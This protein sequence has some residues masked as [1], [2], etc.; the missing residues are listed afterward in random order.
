MSL[1]VASFGFAVGSELRT[2]TI[3]SGLLAAAAIATF[4][5]E[6]GLLT[7]SA[8]GASAA[9]TPATRGSMLQTKRLLMLMLAIGIVVYAGGGAGTFSSFSA[10]TSNTNSSIASGTL[11]MSDNVNATTC[12]S[13][14]APSLD[15]YRASGCGTILSLANQ[16]PGIFGGSAALTLNNT[17]SIDGSKLTVYAPYV[18]TTLSSQ[19]NSGSTIGSLTINTLEGTIAVGDTIELDYGGQSIQMVAGQSAGVPAASY[20]PGMSTPANSIYIAAPGSTSGTLTNGGANV[21]SITTTN[22]RIGMSVT[23]TGI[24]ANTTVSSVSAGSLVLSENATAAGAQTLTFS[25]KANIDFKVGTRVYDV[26]SNASSTKTDCWD[27]ITQTPPPVTG[28]KVGADLNFDGTDIADGS[29][30]DST[31]AYCKTALFWIQEQSNPT[32]SQTGTLNATTTVSGL[33]NTAL[34]SPGMS[35]SGTGIAPN[36]TISTITNATTIVLSIAATGSG[37]Q[38]LTFTANYCW[39]GQGSAN[40]TIQ[41]TNGMCYA[42]IGA[43]FP[44]SGTTTISNATTTLTFASPLAGNIQNGDT[45]TISEP[46]KMVVTCKATQDAYIGATSI[47]VSNV[48][49]NWCTSTATGWVGGTGESFDG[50]SA[51]SPATPATII[52]TT[53]NNGLNSDTTDTISNFDT[54]HGYGNQLELPPLTKNGTHVPSGGGISTLELAKHNSSGDTRIF[55]IGVFFPAGSGTAQNATQGLA[56]NFGLS[57]NL[58]Q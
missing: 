43:Q 18:N 25:V 6:K 54:A 37:S 5:N 1:A 41:T 10:E 56:A 40:A 27:K 14:D 16:A 38:P 7:R 24:S 32:P 23:G 47:T 31:N 42:P 35:V 26:S 28:A 52:D 39:T 21:S 20:T 44:G 30:W 29:H 13:N 48:S 53:I 33:G 51:T 8:A 57:W 19:V 2:V 17:G 34:L 45:I 11:A 15:N 9:G 12:L 55:Y 49:P 22:I 58:Q 4:A 36:T 3:M 50:T 46:K